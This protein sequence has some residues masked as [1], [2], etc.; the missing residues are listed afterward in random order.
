MNPKRPVRSQ[1]YVITLGPLF[2][3][4]WAQEGV[5]EEIYLADK[6]AGG[7]ETSVFRLTSTELGVLLWPL[8]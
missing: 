5:G 1:S 4:A 6:E 8:A 7:G 2:E 3:I